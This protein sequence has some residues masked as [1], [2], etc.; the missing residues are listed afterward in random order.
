[1]SARPDRAVLFDLDGTLLHTAPDLAGAV[2]DMRV[3]RGLEPLPLSELEPLCSYGGRGML[4]RGLDL[5]PDDAEYAATFDAFIERYR[6]RMTRDTHPYEGIRELVR[7]IVG[8]GCA[9]GVVTN[10][11]ESLATPLMDHMAFDPAPGCVV[12]GDS[13][14]VPKPDPAP[15]YLACERIGVA[16]A[17]CIY[18]G[19]SDRDIDAG[20][21]AG[22]ATIGVAYGY[23]PPG[24]DIH[25]WQA[26]RVGARVADLAGLIRE[27][28]DHG[29]A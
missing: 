3:E 12:G 23:I 20:R 10:K 25:G 9:W 16:P 29:S 26:D 8:D 13:A 7:A 14:G 21:A 28:K 15:L 22:M 27:L 5:T 4:G 1:M 24:D 17:R 6:A 18:I 11:I 2:N 19:D